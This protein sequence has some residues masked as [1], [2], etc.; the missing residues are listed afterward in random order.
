[1]GASWISY[2][3]LADIVGNDAAQALCATWG[4]VSIYVPRIPSEGGEIAK[5]I[6]LPALGRL[7]QVY[8][9]EHVVVPNRRKAG[10]SKGKA[11]DL[12]AAGWTPRDVA[13]KLDLTQ[14]YVEYLAKSTRTGTRQG[15][16]LDL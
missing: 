13:L 2:A 15:N 1:M 7:M 14:R 6:G 5:V 8:S 10:P 12:L 4:G 16:L 3:V 9:G 11:L